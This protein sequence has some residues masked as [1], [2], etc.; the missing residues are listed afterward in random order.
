MRF[1]SLALFGAAAFAS[2]FA[3]PHV[4]SACG[5][6]F[7]PPTEKTVV[8]DHRMALAVSKTQ[9]VLWDQ[10]RYAGNPREFAWVLPVRDGA[11]V[12]LS[13]DDW[14]AAL[15]A[16]TSP[17]IIGPNP[18]ARSGCA[19][20]GCGSAEGTSGS[21]G[22][23][24]VEVLRQDV[25]GPYETVTLRSTNPGALRGWLTGHGYAIPTSVAPTIDAY[26]AEGFDFIALRLLPNCNARSMKPVRIVTPG[27]DPTLPLRMVVA[28]IGAFVGLTLYV[29][30]EG[31]YHPQN[32]PDAVVDYGR[33]TWN[34]N[35][36]RSNYQELS[37]EAMQEGG[38]RAWITE[39]AQ[40]P[41]VEDT[42]FS[43]GPN[44]TLFDAYYGL[45]GPSRGGGTGGGVTGDPCSR[46]AGDGDAREDGDDGATDAA[47][48]DAEIDGAADAGELDG[49]TDAGELDGSHDDGGIDAET[50]EPPVEPTWRP[51]G[52][53]A[54]DDLAV[55]LRGMN[56]SDVWVTR[57]RA[58]VRAGALDRDLQ[59][60]T[61]VQV[62]VDNVHRTSVYDEGTVN[63][64]TARTDGCSSSPMRSR[65]DWVGAAALL[66]L[67]VIGV[68]R[69][70]RR[71]R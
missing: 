24:P 49:A 23:D 70:L 41:G 18:R 64:T 6:C 38:D 40:H 21:P 45:C 43:S 52:C 50:W 34:R 63:T 59:L 27:A 16:T 29:V 39:Y 42:S 51:R 19:L 36:G 33:L 25:V 3:V 48:P 65:T 58:N 57:L 68:R 13:R 4:A 47:A 2:A 17:V 55:G 10:I 35:T 20:G 61:D 12:E 71:R 56:P 66:G 62:A 14:F 44:P 22:S 11:R 7:A 30:G 67:T 5:G 32:F 54:F 60:E 9:T 37:L 28:G 46:D 1:A 31:R 69:A 26:V 15:D 53:E 8:T